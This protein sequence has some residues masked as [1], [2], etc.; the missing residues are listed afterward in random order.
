MIEFV[1]FSLLYHHKFVCNIY[2]VAIYFKD[3]I[4]PKKYTTRSG[5]IEKKNI[6]RYY[7]ALRSIPVFEYH[8]G[9]GHEKQT[10]GAMMTLKRYTLGVRF[11]S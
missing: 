8:F 7:S 1:L 5:L 6:C 11:K 4:P 3:L 9:F 2:S 10:S